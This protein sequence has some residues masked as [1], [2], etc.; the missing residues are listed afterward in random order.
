MKKTKITLLELFRVFTKANIDFVLTRFNVGQKE[1]SDDLDVLV[2]PASFQKAISALKRQGYEV[3]SHDNALGGRIPRMQVNLVERGRVKIDL[4][5]DFT[6]RKSHYFDLALIWN[7]A[8]GVKL[9]DAS[10]LV[11]QTNIDAFLVLINVIFEKTYLTRE[12]VDIFWQYKEKIFTNPAF[13]QQSVKYGWSGTFMTFQEWAR[14]QNE[15]QI[16]PVFLP[17]LLVF[18]SYLEKFSLVSFLYYCFFRI[19]F[20]VNGKLPYD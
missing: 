13:Y 5:K 11:P 10:I 15:P 20:L 14:N 18:Y 9:A 8:K 12:E 2:K 7:S 1:D 16:F 4:H 6:W 3:H 17:L 19:R